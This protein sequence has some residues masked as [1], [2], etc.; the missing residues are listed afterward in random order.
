M[1][2]VIFACV[3]NARRSQMAAVFINQLAKPTTVQAISAGTGIPRERCTQSS[4]WLC[5]SI[6]LYLLVDGA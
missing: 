4:V 5:G 1:F 2:R 6:F 3:H